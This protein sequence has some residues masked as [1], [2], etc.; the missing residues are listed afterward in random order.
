MG[1]SGLSGV[2]DFTMEKK[3]RLHVYY[4]VNTDQKNTLCTLFNGLL[5][6]ASENVGIYAL[7]VVKAEDDERLFVT[8]KI[9]KPGSLSIS[10]DQLP[11][12]VGRSQC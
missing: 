10:G 3:K 4:N 5:I 6:R 12:Y 2:K 1:E 7:R 9:W 8:I 11:E